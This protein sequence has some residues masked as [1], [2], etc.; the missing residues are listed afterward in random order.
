VNIVFQSHHAVISDS[1]R[2][3]AERIVLKSASRL[4]R[5]T[6]AVVRFE[7]DGP[8][9]RVEIELNASNRRL[10]ANSAGRFF[11]PALSE[12]GERLLSRVRHERRDQ[13]KKH[14]MRSRRRATTDNS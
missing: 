13:N 3:R 14:T 7:E 11:G 1:M 6:S 10:V 9:R 8:T 2:S 5:V 12:A 4:P